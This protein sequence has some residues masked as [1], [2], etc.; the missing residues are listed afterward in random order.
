MSAQ[1]VPTSGI[2]ESITLLRASPLLGIEPAAIDPD[3]ETPRPIEPEAIE[4]AA[5]EPEAMD[6]AAIDPAAIDP[7]AIEPEAI[8]PAAADW[9]SGVSVAS[10]DAGIDWYGTDLMPAGA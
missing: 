1:V 6:P 5:I 2:W 7:A 3:A 8:E 9:T 10:R 4:P